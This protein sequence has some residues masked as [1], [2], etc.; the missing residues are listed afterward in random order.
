ME[1]AGSFEMLITGNQTVLVSHH[2]KQYVRKSLWLEPALSLMNPVHAHR[3]DFIL[4][5][6]LCL[7][8]ANLSLSLQVSWLKFFYT[9]LTSTM[10]H[11]ADTKYFHIH[12]SLL[13]LKNDQ[14]IFSLLCVMQNIQHI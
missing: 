12:Y 4:S 1:E 11:P 10:S 5:P 14:N 2:W 13:S 7:G 6:H 9:F 8:F 3:P